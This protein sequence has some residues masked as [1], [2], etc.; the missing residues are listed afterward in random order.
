[1]IYPCTK[2]EYGV[3][4]EVCTSSPTHYACT[5][6]KNEEDESVAIKSALNVLVKGKL[7]DG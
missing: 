1:M 4:I 5:H 7:I 6:C 2:C 3:M